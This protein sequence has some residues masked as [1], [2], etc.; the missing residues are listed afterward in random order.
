VR[1]SV[2]RQ[3]QRQFHREAQPRIRE[4]TIPPATRRI[5]S[6]VFGYSGERTRLACWRARPCGREL[7]FTSVMFARREDQRKDCFGA[8]P[9]PAREARALPGSCVIAFGT[10][11]STVPDRAPF[12]HAS[13]TDR[14]L[15]CRESRRRQ[16][17]PSR[18]LARRPLLVG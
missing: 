13:P 18:T 11:T 1:S 10:R 12:L 17:N 7:S 3:D 9:K 14:H 4:R 2:S 5:I 8:T 6:R 15:H 16:W